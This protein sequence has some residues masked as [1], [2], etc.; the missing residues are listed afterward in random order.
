[1]QSRVLPTGRCVFPALVSGGDRDRRHRDHFEPRSRPHRALDRLSHHEPGACVLEFRV[2]L[3][4]HHF[5]AGSA[6]GALA[7]DPLIP[8][9]TDGHCGRGVDSWALRSAPY[10]TGTSNEKPP[11]VAVPTMAI[12]ALVAVTLSAMIMEGAGIDWAAIYMRDVF[13]VPPFLSGFAVALGAGAQALTRFFADPSSSA[14]RRPLCRGGAQSAR[15]SA[16]LVFF[17]PSGW[18]ALVGFGMMGVG[19]SVIFPLAMSAAAQVTDRPASTNV[20]SLAQISF[21]A[22]LLGPPLL[23]YVAEHFGIRWSFGVGLPLVI[24]SIACAKALGKQP[25]KHE[26]E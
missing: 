17:A 4:G 10:R 18:L 24:L 5:G 11:Q 12:M 22:F 2:F 13:A 1:M 8:Y 21:V 20:A 14:I 6:I 9:G 7:A 19:T 15:R 16:L 25:L 23:G 3:G 26:V